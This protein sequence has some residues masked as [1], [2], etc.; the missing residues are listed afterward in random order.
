[1]KTLLAR[2]VL[3]GAALLAGCASLPPR[4]PTPPE[5]A[6]SDVAATRLARVAAA[7]SAGHG[8][9]MSGFRLLPEGE[10]AFNAR[11]ALIRRAE[12]TLDVQYYLINAD[13]VGL[14]FLRELRDAALRGVRVRL[15]VDDLYMAGEDEL[16]SSLA[17]QPNAQVR[18]FNPLPSRGGSFRSR[19]IFSL[20]EFGRINHRMH[21]KLLVA[22]NSFSVSGGRNMANEY[23]MRSAAANFVDLDVLSTGPVVHELSG[24]FDAY[25]NSEH[26]FPIGDLVTGAANGDA[27]RRR[28]DELVAAAPPSVP[29]RPRDV[30]GSTPVGEQLD[31]GALT[32]IFGTAR[33]FADTP[34][35]VAGVHHGLRTVTEQTLHLFATARDEVSIVSPYFIPGERGLAMMR[36]VGATEENGRIT[37]VTNSLGSTDEPLAHAAYARYRLAMLKAGVRIYELSP[38]LARV[39][40]TL[41]NFG[42][43]IGRLHAKAA[44]IDKRTVFIGSMNLDAR[45]ARTNTESGLAITSPELGQQIGVLAR[46]G[47]ASGA[48][49]LRLAADGEHIEWIE[50]KPDGQQIVHTH[51]PN[52]PWLLKLKQWLFAPFVSDELL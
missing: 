33:V 3:C 49:K 32:Q 27:A 18:I 39:S 29:E 5:H 7:A 35:K 43:S 12:K 51:E 41:G 23:F 52:S 15:I 47:L 17:A 45:S 50:T 26:V 34:D 38:S 30:L 46:V 19:L 31:A 10:T 48:Y 6:L 1:L 11:I 25:W 24:V 14:L 44:L 9:G 37:L 2:I 13:E 28:F 4:T 22:D 21:N 8:P 40:G 36:A 20:H 42:R 16:L